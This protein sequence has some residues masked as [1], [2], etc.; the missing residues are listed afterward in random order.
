MKAEL[1]MKSVMQTSRF[2]NASGLASRNYRSSNVA[3]ARKN[4][5][6]AAITIVWQQGIDQHQLSHG[7][8]QM[9]MLISSV[10]GKTIHSSR[11]DS[12]ILGGT[13]RRCSPIGRVYTIRTYLKRFR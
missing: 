5:T 11:T 12:F 8:P 1:G 4:R 2:S 7:M 6:S 13:K 3:Y 9:K 10:F